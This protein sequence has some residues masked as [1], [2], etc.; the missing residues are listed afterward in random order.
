M[1]K[2]EA[3]CKNNQ[4]QRGLKRQILMAPSEI[5][6]WG[7]YLAEDITEAGVLVSEYCGE[8]ITQAEAELRG[9]VY[10][11]FKKISECRKSSWFLQDSRV[12]RELTLL[13]VLY[14]NFGCS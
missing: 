12:P 13:N 6:G 5:A 7:A 8:V 4:L 2:D 3:A 11:T 14:D 1:R 9:R 10:S